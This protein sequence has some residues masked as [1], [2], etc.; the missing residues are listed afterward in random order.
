MTWTRPVRAYSP[1]MGIF[2][3]PVAAPDRT[4]PSERKQKR[5]TPGDPRC[6]ACRGNKRGYCD[7]HRDYHHRTSATAGV[8]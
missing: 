4:P 8:A 5:S 2:S 1:E 7:D 6:R 3:M